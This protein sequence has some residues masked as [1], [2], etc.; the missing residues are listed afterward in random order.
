M[1]PDALTLSRQW[2]HG[3]SPILARRRAIA[4]LAL[5]ATGSMGLIALYQLGVIRRLPEPPLPFFDAEKI[6]SS[7]SAYETFSLPDGLLGLGSYAVTAALAALG[8]EQRA[9]RT[10]WIPLALAGKLAF[11][12][13]QAVRSVMKQWQGGHGFCSWCLLAAATSFA[14]APLAIPETRA[15]LKQL[16]DSK[17]KDWRLSF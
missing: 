15:A 10:P 11:D 8:D 6:V 2:R 1:P 12:L 13:V 9:T 7:P 16:R 4:G 3:S 17:A 5:S 14:A